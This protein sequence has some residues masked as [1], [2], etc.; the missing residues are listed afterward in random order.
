MILLLILIL[1]G[2]ISAH[3]KKSRIYLKIGYMLFLRQNTWTQFSILAMDWDYRRQAIIGYNLLKLL[4]M[5][6][7]NLSSFSVFLWIITCLHHDALATKSF[8]DD[9]FEVPLFTSTSFCRDV[10]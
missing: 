4:N 9:F 3:S 7:R 10:P 8:S 5:V 2:I 1:L 6:F